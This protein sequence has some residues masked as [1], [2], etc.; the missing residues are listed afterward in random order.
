MANNSTPL[1]RVYSWQRTSKNNGAM[2]NFSAQSKISNQWIHLQAFIPFDSITSDE[3]KGKGV[4]TCAISKDGKQ[5]TIRVRKL[6]EPKKAEDKP[7]VEQSFDDNDNEN[8]PF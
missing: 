4:T 3:D 1:Y 7:K 8:M 6:R 2:V 5:L